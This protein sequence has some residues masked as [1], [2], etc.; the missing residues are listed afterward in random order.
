MAKL[1]TSLA[2]TLA[3]RT[4]RYIS[5]CSIDG[6]VCSTATHS[7]PLLRATPIFEAKFPRS[8]PTTD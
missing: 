6:V 4:T 1:E 7:I 2:I 3:I 8:I 5:S